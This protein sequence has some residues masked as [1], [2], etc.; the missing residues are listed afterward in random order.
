MA[1]YELIITDTNSQV[2]I[3]AKGDQGPQG[4]IGPQ[5]PQGTAGSGANNLADLGDVDS[6]SDP[7]QAL[8]SDG[9]GTFSFTTIGGVSETLDSVTGRGN[10][11]TNSISVGGVAATS[12]NTHNIPIGTGTLALTSDIPTVGLGYTPATTTGTVTN[13]AGTDATIPAA[14]TTN[15]GLLTGADKTKLDGIETGA[16]ADQTG[17]EIKSLY[18]AEA[19][20]NAFADADVAK[21]AGIEANA[22]ADQTASEIKTAYESNADTNAYD[23]AAVSKLAG[24]EALATADMTGAEIKTA[25]EAEADTNAFTDSEKTK[26]SGIET[27]ATADQTGDEIKALYELEANAFTDAQFTKLSGIEAQADVTDATNVAAAGAVMDSDIG[28]TVQAHSTVLDNTTASYTTAEETKLSGIE[29]LADVT[30]ATNVDA[31]GAVME[32]DTST[33]NMSFVVDEDDMVSNSGTKVPTQQSVKAYVDANSG[34]NLTVADFAGSAIV[35]ESEGLSTNDNDTSI[36]TTAAVIDY[37]DGAGSVANDATITIS[38]GT[39]LSDGGDFTT[40]QGSNETITISHTNSVTGGTVSEGGVTRPLSYGD[41]FNVPTFT[42]DDQG[43]ISGTGT[44]VALTLPAS[45]NTDTTYT[46][47]D[48]L[49]LTGTTFSHTDTSAATSLTTLSGAAVVSDIDVD[50]Y[51][52]VTGMATRSMALSDLGYTG[53]TDA[54][55]YTSWNVSDGTNTEAIVSGA[56]LNFS[57]GGTSSV[58]YDAASN[59]LTISSSSTSI[60][61]G[62]GLQYTGNS[63]NLDFSELTDMTG[64]ISGGTEFILQDNGTESRKTA[65][66][67]SLSA[68]DNSTSGFTTNTGTV[69]NVSGGSGLSGTVT[70]SGSLAV[71]LTDGVIFSTSDASKAVVRDS[72]GDFSAGTITAAVDLNGA[73]LTLDAD[74]DTTIT[75]ATNDQIDIA[76]GGNDRIQLSTG[77]IDLKNDGSQSEVRLYCESANAHY[78][79]LQAPAHADF[80]TNVTA[81][82]PSDSGTLALTK[83]LPSAHTGAHTLVAADSGKHISITTGGV[84]V[85]TDVFEVGDAVSIYNN[86]GS[87]QT[88]T[89]GTGATLRTAGTA[90]TGD[91]TLAQYGICT[92]LCVVDSAGADEFVVSGGGIS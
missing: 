17:D 35:T 6:S 65:D 14:T 21:L 74:A 91:I 9:D 45:D 8:I 77:V 10:T 71:D 48:G 53:A 61:A 16:T 67:I 26:L 80:S 38:A 78:A 7:G 20:T 70:S 72:N 19:D 62:T 29:S 23:D 41:T 46:A 88:I 39:G 89:Q 57:G 84:T 51:G 13:S 82:L 58:S 47:G 2:S 75:A 22:T 66:G 64:G 44:A 85:D 76:F 59:T 40:N 15:A 68:F 69:T 18:E 56:T 3:L 49:T 33:V 81:T 90:T 50:T 43:H 5:G 11:T 52:H 1:K 12:L 37:V 36:P 86:S 42:F 30:D 73:A 63:L 31:A 87:D 4:E 83:I 24:I 32:S 92:I 28:S 60:S 25:Y 55:N 79:A 34:S 27:G 54:D